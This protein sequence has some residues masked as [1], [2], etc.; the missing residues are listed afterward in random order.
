MNK[1]VPSVK[2]FMVSWVYPVN[3]KTFHANLQLSN[4]AEPTYV[5]SMLKWKSVL[6]AHVYVDFPAY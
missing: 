4:L 6:L 1:K 3:G 2:T 5:H